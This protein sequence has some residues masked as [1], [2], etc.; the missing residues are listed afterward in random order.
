MMY[1]RLDRYLLLFFCASYSVFAEYR[2]FTS[3]DGA[4][5]EAEIVSADESKV[6]IR[7]RDGR[8]FKEVGY[9]R[10]S[11]EDRSYIRDWVKAQQL[12]VD[13]AD[14]TPDAAFRISFLKGRDDDFNEYGDID[15]RIVS[16]EPEVVIESQDYKKTYPDIEGTV[17][18]VGRG[19]VNDKQYAVLSKQE[20]GMALKPRAKARWVGKS[21]ECRYDPD[22]GGFEYGGYIIV[23]R[24]RAGEIVLVKA[25][26]S[27]WE[28]APERLLKAKKRTGYNSDFSRETSLHTTFGLPY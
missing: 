6:T 11:R 27:G 21:F 14:V 26:K 7:L 4:E 24:N 1:F 12:L 2:N 23:I 15:D 18:V 20:F 22:Y 8:L 25:S 17:V 3:P 9:E 5:I 16:F 10:F 19:V 28:Q 13:R